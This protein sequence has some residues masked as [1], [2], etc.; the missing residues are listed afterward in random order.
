MFDK[1]LVKYQ[2]RYSYYHQD[3]R[4]NL[5]VFSSAKEILC[6]VL[7]KEPNS[8]NPPMIIVVNRMSTDCQRYVQNKKE[9]ERKHNPLCF[10]SRVWRPR[11]PTRYSGRIREGVQLLSVIE[12]GN[13]GMISVHFFFI[14]TI[15]RPPHLLFSEQH[16]LF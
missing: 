16:L 8:V 2:L 13:K 14:I 12:G 5:S 15:S 7:L 4:N 6:V 9:K 3:R 11:W 1:H 10:V